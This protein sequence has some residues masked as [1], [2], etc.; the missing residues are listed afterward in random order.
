ELA[1]DDGGKLVIR[2]KLTQQDIASRIGASREMVSKILNDLATG[3][4]L[5]IARKRITLHKT[6]PRHW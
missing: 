6:P 2:E 1:Q 4:Y 3:G 5:S